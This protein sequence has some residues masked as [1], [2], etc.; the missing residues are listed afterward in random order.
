MTNRGSK[1]RQIK[2]RAASR[3]HGKGAKGGTRP[4]FIRSTSFYV[5]N[6]CSLAALLVIPAKAFALLDTGDYEGR[7]IASIE[8][9]F[10][11]SATDEAVQAEFVAML[12]ITPHSEYSAVLIR[13][14][15]QELFR[16]GR[17]AAARV[18]VT[19][20]GAKNG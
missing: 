13:D 18:E 17:V 16:S 19:E 12:K 9:V 3:M 4:T 15:L 5:I 2:T 20:T 6:I 11:A 8:V 7:Q 14:S 10:E 1:L